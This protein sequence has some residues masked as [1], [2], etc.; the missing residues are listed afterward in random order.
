MPATYAAVRAALAHTIEIVPDFAPASLL[1]AGAGPGTASWAAIDAWPSVQRSTLI[2]RNPRLLELAAVLGGAIPGGTMAIDRTPGDLAPTLDAAASA[3]V[4]LASY[5]LT[6][7]A[8]GAMAEVL[9]ALWRRAGRLLLIV[10]PGTADGFRRILKCRDA[11]IAGGA[12][13]IAPCS[14]DGRCPLSEAARWCHF[15]ARLSRSRDH[16]IAK[17]ASVPF[18][19][20]KYC[21][22]AAGKGFGEIARGRRILATPKAAKSGIT[23][24]LCAPETAAVHIVERRRKD[25][26]KAARRLGW[27]D[28]T[29]L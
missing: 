24:T 15:A 5:A 10:E 23:L 14:H 20:E 8:E 2:D 27:G 3:D 29:R 16:L 25:A 19:D 12:Q 28:M 6:E 9:A 4:V 13:L 11:L 1:D 18:E 17:D 22:L 7:I 26:Y 21:Y